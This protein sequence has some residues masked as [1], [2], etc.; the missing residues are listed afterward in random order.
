[1]RAAEALLDNDLPS[2]SASCAP[3]L[4]DKPTDVAAIRMMAELAGAAR[5][6]RAMPRSCCAARSSWRPAS[7]RRAPISPPCSTA[8]TAPPRRSPS[9]T[10][11]RRASRGN[12][13][14]QNLKA[15]ALG[16]IGGYEEAIALYEQVLAALPD[17]PK[18][19]MSYGH[20]LKTVGRQDDGIAAYRRALA[21][22]PALGE[23]WWSLA[24]LKTVRFADDD[25][26]AMEAALAA[27]DLARED[28]FHLHFAL[29]KAF[30]ERASPSAAFA[31]Y[32]E[33]NRLRARDDRLR[34]PT[35]PTR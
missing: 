3:R 9:S 24:N 12:P 29:G 32:A 33:G 8:R 28:R 13:G 7:P 22:A 15:A 11:A 2:P 23:V 26:A 27:P 25:V 6:L 30:E 35:R 1:M 5:P 20:A 21:L 19:W 31:H 18:V 14:H 17:Q 4:N 16:R 10:A 34:S